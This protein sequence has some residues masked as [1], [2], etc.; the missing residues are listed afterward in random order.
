[1]AM[2]RRP[3][4]AVVVLILIMTD[5]T[6]GLIPMSEKASGSAKN[7]CKTCID[8][9]GTEGE[10][11][12]ACLMNC[13]QAGVMAFLGPMCQK[14]CKDSQMCSNLCGKCV[15]CAFEKGE[16][17][18]KCLIKCVG[19]SVLLGPLCGE[20]CSTATA[21]S[22]MKD[23]D[24]CTGKC[25]ECASCVFEDSADA[26]K[27]CALNCV[28]KDLVLG[29]LCEKACSKAKDAAGCTETCMK[30]ADCAPCAFKDTDEEKQLCALACVGVNFVFDAVCEKACSKTEN[31]GNCTAMCLK[32]AKDCAPCAMK[33]TEDARE[34]C[35]IRTCVGFEIVGPLCEN[36]FVGDIVQKCKECGA[37]AREPQENRDACLKEC[38]G[39][40]PEAFDVCE[41][42]SCDPICGGQRTAACREQCGSDTACIESCK[43]SCMDECKQ[44]CGSCGQCGY[45]KSREAMH[46][47]T[48]KYCVQPFMMTPVCEDFCSNSLMGLRPQECVSICNSCEDCI[49]SVDCVTGTA[50]VESCLRECMFDDACS[51]DCNRMYSSSKDVDDCKANCQSCKH[52]ANEDN[53]TMQPCL[54]ECFESLDVKEECS[55][56]CQ[57]W[58]VASGDS[59]TR[60]RSLCASCIKCDGLPGSEKQGCLRNCT[61]GQM[62][63]YFGDQC[64]SLCRDQNDTASCRETC[65][66]CDSCVFEGDGQNMTSCILDKCIPPRDVAVPICEE[67]CANE[68]DVNTCVVSCMA[69]PECVHLDTRRK[70]Q[71]C[72][73]EHVAPAQL[74]PS[75]D[76]LC[77]ELP[78]P[79]K[80]KRRCRSCNLCMNDRGTNRDGCLE[81]CADRGRRGDSCDDHCT[82]AKDPRTCRT[83]CMTCPMCDRL[84][85]EALQSC[86]AECTGEVTAQMTFDTCDDLCSTYNDF[87]RCMAACGDCGQ[88]SMGAG[89]YDC[90][91]ECVDATDPGLDFSDKEKEKKK[92]AKKAMLSGMC[93]LM[94]GNIWDMFSCDLVCAMGGVCPIVDER[95]LL[96]CPP[97]AQ[98][99]L[100]LY[101]SDLITYFE[102]VALFYENM[103]KALDGIMMGT[104]GL[105]A[106]CNY[107]LIMLQTSYSTCSGI[108][109]P[110][111]WGAATIPWNEWM[112][113]IAGMTNCQ[114]RICSAVAGVNRCP[115]L[116][117]TG[118]C[119]YVSAYT[120]CC[121]WP[122]CCPS[123]I[124][125][126]ST[127]V[128]VNPTGLK[129]C[130]R[131]VHEADDAC[132]MEGLWWRG[133]VEAPALRNPCHVVTKIAELKNYVHKFRTEIIP[134][135]VTQLRAMRANARR[136][137]VRISCSSNIKIYL[138]LL[139]EIWDRANHID[140]WDTEKF[141][142]ETNKFTLAMQ[143]FNEDINSGGSGFGFDFSSGGSGWTNFKTGLSVGASAYFDNM[144]GKN[145]EKYLVWVPDYNP[146]YCI[147]GATGAVTSTVTST[148]VDKIVGEVKKTA[149]EKTM[150]AI[151]STFGV[152]QIQALVTYHTELLALSMSNTFAGVA[153]VIGTWCNS[154]YPMTCIDSF[155]LRWHLVEG[156]NLGEDLVFNMPV[157]PG[158]GVEAFAKSMPGDAFWHY[159]EC[160][161]YQGHTPD[162]TGG[163]EEELEEELEEEEEV[164]EEE[165]SEEEDEELEEEVDCSDK[166]D[167]E[168]CYEGDG[169][170][171]NSEC[172]PGAEACTT[173]GEEE[174]ADAEDGAT[175]S[176]GKGLCC[177]GACVPGASGCG[178]E[179]EE[180]AAEEDESPCDGGRCCEG[181]CVP[182]ATGCS[183]TADCIKRPDGTSCGN[184]TGM[185]CE[186]NCIPGAE[187]CAVASGC[188]V[189][190]D[191]LP[192]KEGTCCDGVC[193][194][195]AASCGAYSHECVEGGDLSV[196]SGDGLCCRDRC[197]PGATTCG[198]KPGSELPDDISEVCTRACDE[199]SGGDHYCHPTERVCTCRT[200]RG[201]VYIDDIPCAPRVSERLV[202][203]LVRCCESKGMDEVDH[204]YTVES[205]TGFCCQGAFTEVPIE[206]ECVKDAP[207]VEIASLAWMDGNRQ[208]LSM[209]AGTTINLTAVLRNTGKRLEDGDLSF[210][211]DA[212]GK[213]H[214]SRDEHHIAI[215]GSSVRRV[216][217]P[218][219]LEARLAGRSLT[220]LAILG[221]LNVQVSSEPARLYVLAED[222]VDVADGYF[223]SSGERDYYV[224]AGD[225]VAAA[226]ALTSS[227]D[228]AV[229]AVIEVVMTAN[230]TEL[231]STR[232]A[233]ATT[234]E[235][236]ATVTVRTPTRFIGEGDVDTELG[237]VVRVE[238]VG[239]EV[240]QYKRLET[241]TYPDAVRSVSSPYL[242]LRDVAWRDDGGRRMERT[243]EGV[244]TKAEVTLHNPLA[245]SFDGTVTV[246]VVDGQGNIVATGS[247]HAV[248]D[249]DASAIVQTVP[250]TTSLAEAFAVGTDGSTVLKK[251][252][253]RYRVRVTARTDAI[254]WAD[255]DDHV[256]VLETRALG[257]GG[258]SDVLA[259]SE[260]E[261]CSISV[262][263]TAC[264]EGCEITIMDCEPVLNLCKCGECTFTRV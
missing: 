1:M 201:P 115:Q 202:A 124:A 132:T 28:V 41:Q 184:G 31:P 215:S 172:I 258:T 144:Q 86:I 29:P 130:H 6:A 239:G 220:A 256:F 83:A 131:F 196:C 77:E 62:E 240:L 208:V 136:C 47:C 72:Y 206:I 209:V 261:G 74:G 159:N 221:Y 137:T 5:V 52:C 234:L 63:D 185:C 205:E 161:L 150:D 248:I 156:E 207:V 229:E 118:T 125:T 3:V 257:E 2:V 25:T 160:L 213:R 104:V 174:C 168:P 247:R 116:C 193:V 7:M 100:Y 78:E 22:W 127:T 194:P 198:G 101:Y 23:A 222:T 97:M 135:I 82:T 8:C 119:H 32:V 183:G 182:G 109:N 154:G 70:R 4:V 162:P 181:R 33:P 197:L 246:E 75:C 219:E 71:D 114:P 69:K 141:E 85:G 166:E 36:L 252:D 158:C 80:C 245:M 123:Y 148:A 140:G 192:C 84:E 111:P 120:C 170:C 180:C 51:R 142:F 90:L 143:D 21:E 211:V 214:I 138:D 10:E 210:R 233:K 37:C 227:K 16:G 133:V 228:E 259:S 241:D 260:F 89:Q 171:C 61:M 232:T 151:K 44:L 195:G 79:D 254:T 224:L 155:P 46:E 45:E 65:M 128:H 190:Y 204:C 19:E 173:E 39:R 43:Q 58:E 108:W 186:Q 121:G 48:I 145:P 165:E 53:V 244:P 264:T 225:V 93:D 189:G 105:C 134:D 243:Y 237:M 35:L 103:E 66:N 139:E 249:M 67:I 76:Q 175:C 94:F 187:A 68:P 188:Q 177:F 92:K 199:S 212:D 242:F 49:M 81:R 223:E 126:P 110:T 255:I 230:G 107:E 176:G 56:L 54:M 14:I 169:L 129:S 20:L 96:K 17:A 146:P 262:S 122:A 40:Q 226:A 113:D 27:E 91:E 157:I 99:N 163:G 59:M 200:T 191:G 106:M 102:N 263:C 238:G 117:S 73:T 149:K 88:C 24:K 235:R 250:F 42:V 34:E 55:G 15:P 164:E 251:E 98:E 153:G 216:G 64:D 218:V 217:L 87:D 152:K 57:G 13:L 50:Q 236:G 30:L 11:Q 167:Q 18:E 26:R 147:P 231:G 203:G 60:C 179:E 95:Y 12:N 253:S 9:V 38:V 112:C 178:E